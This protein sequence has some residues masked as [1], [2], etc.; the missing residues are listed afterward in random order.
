MISVQRARQL[1]HR[2]TRPLP[3]TLKPLPSASGLVLAGEVRSPS[4]YPLYDV[5]AMDGYA[6]KS[7]DVRQAS[8]SGP[9]YL[10]LKGTQHAGDTL[11]IKIKPG[12]C[13]KVMTG[14]VIPAGADAVLEREVVVEKNGMAVI[15]QAAVKGRHIRYRGEGIKKGKAALRAGSILH[16]RAIGFLASLGVSNVWVRSIPRVAL[17]VTGNELVTPGK[18]LKPGQIYN[19]NQWMLETALRESGIQP[20]FVS[21]LPDKPALLKNK[22]KKALASCDVLLLVGGVSVGDSDFSKP[23]L[24][25]LGVQRVFWRVSQKPGFPLYFGRKGKTLVFGLPGNPASAWVNFYEYVMPCLRAMRGLPTGPRT[26]KA[27]LTTDGPHRGFKTLFLKARFR[28]NAGSIQADLLMG[29]GSHLLQSLAEGNCLAVVPSG[30]GRIK[31]G[32]RI[33][34]HPLPTGKSS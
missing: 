32:E 28:K 20:G 15:T 26:M 13:R 19:S 8:L 21:L 2:Y 5:S 11:G 7:A 1:I 25:S 31:K 24:E 17:I 9:I 4:D 30:K 29:Q 34:I 27:V 14:G 10:K 22:I 23:I 3:P 16:S 12:E 6:L 18:K 33:E